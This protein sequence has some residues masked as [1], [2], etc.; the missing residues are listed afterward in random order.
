[1]ATGSAGCPGIRHGKAGRESF[2][3]DEKR[4]RRIDGV[5]ASQGQVLTG[6]AGPREAYIYQ[7]SLGCSNPHGVVAQ[8]AEMSLIS[9]GGC[10][11][12]RVRLTG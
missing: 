10:S 1:M 11:V 9:G 2:R 3:T 6:A 7:K 4:P 8:G 5:G 12:N